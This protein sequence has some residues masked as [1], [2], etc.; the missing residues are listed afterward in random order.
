[1][2]RS[3]SVR[4]ELVLLRRT[5]REALRAAARPRRILVGGLGLGYTVRA[6]LA[7]ARVERVVVAEIEPAVVRWL[8]RGLV[9]EMSGLLD[10]PR[11]D[12]RVL[13]VRKLLGATEPGGFDA[14]LLDVDNGPEQLV[15]AGN[16]ALYGEAG[17]ALCLSRCAVDGILA[18]WSAGTSSVLATSL[19]RVAGTAWQVPLAVRLQGRE[20]SHHAYLARPPRR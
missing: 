6:L 12:V 9:P 13:D 1:M 7:D 17:L 15:H 2:A 8:R 10:D 5:G 19:A 3:H 20:T 18:V 16:A 14:V 11:V 4:G